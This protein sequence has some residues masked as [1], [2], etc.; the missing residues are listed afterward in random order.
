MLVFIPGDGSSSTDMRGLA[1]HGQVLVV[2]VQYRLGLLAGVSTG[3]SVAPG[4]L[5]HWDVLLALRWINDNIGYFGGDTSSITLAG[6]SGGAVLATTLML[7]PRAKALFQQVI[8][9]SGLV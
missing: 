3:D 2:K 7:S 6:H 5:G 8:A 9:M 4:N 1:L